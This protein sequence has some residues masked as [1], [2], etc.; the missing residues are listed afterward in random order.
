MQRFEAELVFGP[1]ATFGE[2]PL[3]DNRDR[4]LWWTDIPG[5]TVHRY[6]P[7]THQDRPIPVEMNVGSIVLRA[8]GGVVV[9]ARDGFAALASDG[10]LDMIAPLNADD[11]AIRMNDGKCDAAGR[12]YASTM[13]FNAE[14]PVGELLRLDSDHSVHVQERDLI[15]GNGMDWSADHRIMYFTDTLDMGIDAFDV[16][17]ATG[18]LSGRRR[19]FDIDKAHGLPDGFC[20]DNEGALWVAMWKGSSVRRYSPDGE[21]LAIVDVPAT[22]VTCPSFGGDNLDE[23]FITT[24]QP[25]LSGV[26]KVEPLAG[27][28]FRIKPGVGGPPPTPFAG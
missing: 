25:Q 10:T 22:N 23:L 17:T 8:S 12:F 20:I 5:C 16:D 21:L 4:V 7:R 2:G 27:A 9:A 11:P 28:I 14:D 15:I 18:D 26:E 19:L 24:A 13:A 6:D 1:T 3:W